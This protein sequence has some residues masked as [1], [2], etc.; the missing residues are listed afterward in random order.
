M[1]IQVR[2]PYFARRDPDA[3]WSIVDMRTGQIVV[4]AETMP[5]TIKHLEEDTIME[6]LDALCARDLTSGWATSPLRD[7]D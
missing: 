2:A 5:L 6:I 1:I 4:I 3:T 7:R